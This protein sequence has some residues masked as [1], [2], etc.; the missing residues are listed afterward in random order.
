MLTNAALTGIKTHLTRTVAYARYKVGSTWYR[1]EAENVN[2]YVASSGYVNIDFTANPP[3][4]GEVTISA[5][6]IYNTAGELWLT[7]AESTVRK[8]TQEGV[9]YRFQVAITEV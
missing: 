5:V 8:N 1:V 4:S 3:V 7:K 9:F 2:V 6:E